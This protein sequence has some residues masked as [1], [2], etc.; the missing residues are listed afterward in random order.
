MAKN[1][2]PGPRG[3]RMPT[4]KIDNPIKMLCKIIA[5]IAKNYAPHLIVVVICIVLGVLANVRGTWFTKSLV[6]KYI[7]GIISQKATIKDYGELLNA[8]T[9]IAIFYLIGILSIFI[10]N[11]TMV[12]VTQGTLKKLRDK[13]FLHMQG[14]PIKYFDTHTYG[15]I[16]SMYTN[17]IDTLR[18]MIAMAL[19]QIL[20][21]AI[22]I[23]SVFVAMFMLNKPLTAFT[24]VMVILVV[25]LTKLLTS[26]S[27]KNF[28]KQQRNLAD[29]NGYI[30]EMMTGQKVVKVFC[31]E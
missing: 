26:L 28:I 10:Q 27:G 9:K 15:D 23:V 5:F 12:F 6:D 16:M 8:M 1:N 4:E 22:T 19:P 30:E 29:V 21:S 2:V 14:L 31:H 20:N 7:P 25:Y 18:Q 13:M 3:R 24:L 17:D 11:E